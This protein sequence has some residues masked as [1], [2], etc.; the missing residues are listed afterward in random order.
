MKKR[1]LGVLG[2]V[3]SGKGIAAK[4]IARKY[5]YNILVMGNIVRALAKREK[6]KPTRDNLEHL[7]AK[8]AKKYHTDYIMKLALE[9]AMKSKKPVIIDGIRKPIQ[10]KLARQK[11]KAKLILVDASP[12]IRF[13]RMKKRRR[14]GFSKT[15]KD[16]IRV[17]KNEQKFFNLKRTFSM[18][19]FRVDNSN[20]KKYLLKQLDQIMKK[21][22]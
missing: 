14:K 10:A 6:I 13:E 5:G 16:F 17:E 18:A 3:G 21:L 7:Q 8:Y 12:E 4:Y 2:P 19:D 22:K 9:K 20:G 11:L 1:N 15:L